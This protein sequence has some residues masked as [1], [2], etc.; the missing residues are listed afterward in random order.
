MCQ[1][2]LKDQRLNPKEIKLLFKLRTRMLNCKENFKNKYQGEFLFCELCKISAD[3]QSHLMECHILTNCVPELRN[4]VSTKYQDIFK[5]I[6]KQV[7]A[8]KLLTRVVEVR[9]LLLLKKE[10]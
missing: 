1:D 10:F 4:N 6:D 2:Y 5:N 8:I 9:D 3:S 7:K